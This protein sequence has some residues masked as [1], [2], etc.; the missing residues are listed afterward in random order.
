MATSVGRGLLGAFLLL[1]SGCAAVRPAQ[2]VAVDFNRAFA[3]SRDETMLLNVLRAAGRQP[4]QFSTM[5]TVTGSARGSGS[6]SLPFANL[7]GGSSP[8]TLSPS[9]SMSE[10]NPNLSII[11]LSHR[12]FA[13]GLLAPMTPEHLSFFLN[14]GWGADFL[15]PLAIGGVNCPGQNRPVANTGDYTN[16]LY[17][18]FARM[19]ADAERRGLTIDQRREDQGAPT[20]LRIAAKDA[21]AMMQSG[22]GAGRRIANV[23]GDGDHAIVELQQ[24]RSHWAVTGIDTSIVCARGQAVAASPPRSY[25]S[26]VEGAADEP[27]RAGTQATGTLRLRSVASMMYFLGE[28]QRIWIDRELRRCA[29][30]APEPLS[31]P[32]WPTYF[33]Y[34]SE[35]QLE[36]RILFR[37]GVA[38]RAGGPAASVVDTTFN[39]RRF[40]LRALAGPTDTDRTLKTLAFLSELIALQTSQSLIESSSPS[41]AVQR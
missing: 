13:L 28:T 36:Y 10:G 8:F 34:N 16:P 4:L 31:R 23:T 9:L 32:E 26:M 38:C 15:L 6:I 29:G 11:P 37:V 7:I 21:L 17:D 30:D 3:E 27:A 14:Q 18:D 12:E 2:R 33:S 19:F 1:A 41:I 22:V 20:R 24:T 40:F 35:D 39:G 5:G 25:T